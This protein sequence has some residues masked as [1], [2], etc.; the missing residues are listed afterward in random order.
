MTKGFQVFTYEG[1]YT[2]TVTGRTVELAG[3]ALFGGEIFK[4]RKAAKSAWYDSAP[5][6]ND[7][8]TIKPVESHTYEEIERRYPVL[9]SAM[10]WA[11]ILC[12]TE[13]VDC[14]KALQEHRGS[15]EAVSH[16][17]GPRA[18]LAAALRCRKF[19]Y[20]VRKEQLKACKYCGISGYHLDTCRYKYPSPVIIHRETACDFCETIEQA[21]GRYHCPIHQESEAAA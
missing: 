11:A 3:R 4:T 19:A 20:Q 15:G 14:I 7:S 16:F 5:G 17:G 9:I 18:V 1:S 12:T 13:A 8:M 6:R 2:S 10:K 21:T